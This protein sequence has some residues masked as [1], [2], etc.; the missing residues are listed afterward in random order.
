[1]GENGDVAM[2][3]PDQMAR[4]RVAAGVAIGAHRVEAGRL[5]AAVEQHGRRQARAVRAAPE[6][7]HRIVARRHDDEAVDAARDQ[8]LD[9]PALDRRRPR[10]VETMQEIVAVAFGERL[11]AVHEAGEKDV[12]DVGDDHADEAGGPAAQARS[13]RGRADSRALRSLREPCGGSPRRPGDCR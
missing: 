13:R 8:R 4:R 7:G 9:A 3:E 12:G 11:D 1:M 5:G 2:P 6:R 10:S